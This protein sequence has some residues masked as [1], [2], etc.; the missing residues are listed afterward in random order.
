MKKRYKKVIYIFTT[1]VLIS[2]IGGV[3]KYSLRYIDDNPDKYIPQYGGWCAYGFSMLATNG[4]IGK[5]DTNPE[6]FKIING[7]LYLFKKEKD[8]DA[9]TYWNENLDKKNVKK[10]DV[11]WKLLKN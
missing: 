8:Y 5:Y 6:S 10:A 11:T 1:I 7:K 9:L 2:I 4:K 3:V